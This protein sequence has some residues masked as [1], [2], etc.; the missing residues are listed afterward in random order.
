MIIK[1]QSI[2]ITALICIIIV[3]IMAFIVKLSINGIIHGEELKL[4]TGFIKDGVIIHD[5]PET[6]ILFNNDYI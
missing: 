2:K 6:Y 1:N 4:M 3:I 5:R